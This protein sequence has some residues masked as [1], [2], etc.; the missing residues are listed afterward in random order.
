MTAAGTS[1][2]TPPIKRCK[3]TSWPPDIMWRLS[4]WPRRRPRPIPGTPDILA[5]LVAGHHRHLHEFH[6]RARNGRPAQHFRSSRWTAVVAG[7]TDAAATIPT[8]SRPVPASALPSSHLR[9]RAFNGDLIGKASFTASGRMQTETTAEKVRNVSPV[10]LN[11]FRV[12]AAAN[13]TNSFIELYNA[14][15][16]DVDLSNWTL[17]EHPTQQAIFSNVKSRPG[18]NSPLTVST[19]SACPLPASRSPPQ[20]RF[21]HL[22]RTT[23]GM[24]AGDS[25]A[26]DNETH[27]IAAIGTA[28]ARAPRCGNPPR[29]SGNYYPAGATN[30]PFTAQGGGRGGP[31]QPPSRSVTGS[32]S[33]MA[34]PTRCRKAHREIR[35]SN[36]HRDRQARHAG[37]PGGRRARRGEKYFCHQHRQYHGG[38]QNRAGYR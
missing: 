17:T 14:G 19:C 6:R 3:P 22:R 24:N 4:A 20:G 8:R 10:K 11:E 18:P 38:R 5:S 25:I 7:K 2:R 21:D 29:R 30:V 33:A 26:I 27:K 12:S 16:G 37:F 31:S 13:P 1:R 36:G 32:P 15:S 35:N 28:P 23:T 9:T 34:P